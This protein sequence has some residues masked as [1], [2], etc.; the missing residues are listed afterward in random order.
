MEKNEIILRRCSKNQSKIRWLC[1]VE[2]FPKNQYIFFISFFLVLFVS[3]LYATW[4]F[5]FLIFGNW[6]NWIS[7]DKI[8]VWNNFWLRRKKIDLKEIGSNDS[9]RLT[10]FVDFVFLGEENLI[11]TFNC[12]VAVFIIWLLSSRYYQS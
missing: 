7:D 8:Q 11:I 10:F 12:C 5:C 2:C 1:H 6:S 3:K 9:I 4:F